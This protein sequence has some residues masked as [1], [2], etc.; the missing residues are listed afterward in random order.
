M[1]WYPLQGSARAWYVV[2]LVMTTTVA[3][4]S[5]VG[6]FR[7]DPATTL[8]VVCDGGECRVKVTFTPGPRAGNDW[9]L[10]RA[11]DADERLVFWKSERVARDGFPV[12]HEFSLPAQKGVQQIRLLAGKQRSV[13]RVEFSRSLPVGVCAQRGRFYPWKPEVRGA[14]VYV[15][16]QASVLEVSGGPLVIKD[17]SGKT[18]LNHPSPHAKGSAHVPRSG[19]VLSVEFPKRTEWSFQMRGFPFILC[20]SPEVARA[21][22]ASVIQLPDGTIVFHRFQADIAQLLPKLLEPERIGRVQSLVADLR[23]REPRW[24]EDPLR[25][26]C[27]LGSYGFMEHVN[28]S[29]RMQ[30]VDPRSPTSGAITLKKGHRWAPYAGGGSLTGGSLA[31]GLAQAAVLDAPF[32][33]WFGKRELLYR[34]A[35]C[36]LRDLMLLDEDE[37][38]HSGTSSDMNPYPTGC[39]LFPLGHSHVGPFGLA[40]PLMPSEVRGVWAEALRHA[41]DRVFPV[42]LVTCRNQSSYTLT[43]LWHYYEG[44]GDKRYRDVACRYSERFL[45]GLTKRC[46]DMEACG[47]DATYQGMTDW[48]KGMFLR[49]TGDPNMKESLRLTYRFFNHTVAPEPDGTMLGASNFSHRTAGSFAVEQWGGARGICDDLLP[50]VGIWAK[51]RTAQAR[52]KAAE[53]IRKRLAQP[54][55]DEDYATPGGRARGRK[56]SQITTPRYLYYTQHPLKDIWPAQERKPFIRNFGDEMIAVK[57]GGYYCVIYVGKPAGEYYIRGREKFRKPLPG[58]I[59]NVGGVKHA[60]PVTPYLGGGLSVFWTPAYGNALLGMNWSPLTHQGLVA[61]K[62]DGTRWWED[63][64]KTQFQLDPNARM[65]TVTG[66]LEGFPLAYERR[67]TFDDDALRVDLRLTALGRVECTRLVENIPLVFGSVKS[68][69]VVLDAPARG[70]AFRVSDQTGAG[71]EW[72]FADPQ[73]FSAYRKGLRGQ[74]YVDHV[75][76]RVEVL[77]PSRFDKGQHITLGYVLR[78]LR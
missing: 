70:R 1:K 44:S 73:Q 28:W 27:L 63:Y 34:A 5:P 48:H 64:H 58:N 7:L 75:C 42:Q 9:L 20:P 47:P 12:V 2:A 72:E 11:F 19:A 50:E 35:A 32:N 37:T 39:L 57:R 78:G 76:G 10:T 55:A 14:W 40:A 3:T 77:L 69:G 59:E 33:P 56:A 62:A 26:I 36:A 13:A 53:I 61:R 6:L 17:E 30:D 46:F 51:P 54:F 45:E 29:L 31:T 38:F 68:R 21:I 23:Q 25:N 60:K 22:R 8:Y 41:V 66:Q 52:A 24:L 4:S 67:Y 15:P 18:L 16:P 71:V 65:L 74:K 43:I 49:L